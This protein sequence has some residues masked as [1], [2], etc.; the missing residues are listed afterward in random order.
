MLLYLSFRSPS[1]SRGECCPGLKSEHASPST[2]LSSVRV[3]S[4]FLGVRFGQEPDSLL[5]PFA[6]GCP[7]LFFAPVGSNSSRELGLLL[8][9]VANT[10]F[11]GGIA[12]APKRLNFPLQRRNPRPE[13]A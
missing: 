1:A 2:A 7:R 10:V 12:V 11:S 3:S 5:T 8:S 6:V 4:H 9:H 13:E